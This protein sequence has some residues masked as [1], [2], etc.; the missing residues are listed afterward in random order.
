MTVQI[1]KKPKHGPRPPYPSYASFRNYIRRLGE[2]VIPSQIDRSVFGNQSGTYISLMIGAFEWF[3][4]IDEN[5]RPTKKLHDLV[6]CGESEYPGEL[7]VLLLESYDILR[8]DGINLKNGTEHQISKIFRE[9][10]FSGSTLT[11]A[12]SF[13][14]SA[15]KDAGY[16]IGDHMRAPSPPRGVGKKKPK[17]ATEKN[18]KGSLGDDEDLNSDIDRIPEGMERITVPLR[19]MDDGVIYFPKGLEESE[20]RKAVKM[21]KFILNNFYGLDDD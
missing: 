5:G 2:S 7:K 20:A 10:G 6:S 1:I 12:V 19:G 14:L 13:F 9:Y 15:C 3:K 4:L 17:S 16:E 8:E 11:K 18:T 21:A